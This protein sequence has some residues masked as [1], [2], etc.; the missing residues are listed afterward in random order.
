MLDEV[1]G[2]LTTMNYEDESTKFACLKKPV[3]NTAAI[4]VIWPTVL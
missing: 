3:Y 4:A 1:D 2:G